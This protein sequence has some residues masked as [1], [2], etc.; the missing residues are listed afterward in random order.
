MEGELWRID[1]S[2]LPALDEYEE[3]PTLFARRFIA[4]QGVTEPVLGY[5]FQQDVTGLPDCGTHWHQSGPVEDPH[6]A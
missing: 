5:L 6:R 1:A 3:A 2:L 4:I